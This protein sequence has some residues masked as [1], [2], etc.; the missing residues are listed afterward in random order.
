[1]RISI[2][3]EGGSI[4]IPTTVA[5]VWFL[6]A[7]VVIL[8]LM[9][10][11]AT[12]VNWNFAFNTLVGGAGGT[13]HPGLGPL[14]VILAFAGYLFVPAIVAAVVATLVARSI[15]SRYDDK[16]LEDVVKEIIQA[17]SGIEVAE[18][19]AAKD[20]AATEGKTAAVKADRPNG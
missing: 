7:A 10:I 17:T 5:L 4:T 11:V 14:G 8:I 19:Q 3:R 13:Y 16:P 1:M 6:G 20:K 2:R 9:V 15:D 12:R 18:V